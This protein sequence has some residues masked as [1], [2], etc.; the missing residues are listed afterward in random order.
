MTDATKTYLSALAQLYATTPATPEHAEAQAGVSQAWA[1]LN[2][3]A[4]ET[5]GKRLLADLALL[6]EETFL[7]ASDWPPIT[8]RD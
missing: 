2:G 3:S 4:H 5:E 6:P 8:M 7:T 1:S